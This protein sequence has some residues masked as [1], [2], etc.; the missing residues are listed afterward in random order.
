MAANA[1]TFGALTELVEPSQIVFGT[2]YPYMPDLAVKQYLS[3]IDSYPRFDP[4]SKSE[5]LSDNAMSLFPRI[6]EKR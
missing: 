2:D 6:N 5:V 4:K 3:E 1:V